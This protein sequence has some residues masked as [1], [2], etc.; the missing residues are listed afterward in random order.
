MRSHPDVERAEIAGDIRRRME[1]AGRI[2]I[3]AGCR[4]D[5]VAVA[6]SFTRI[7]AVQSATGDGASVDVQ[8]VDGA[9][10]RLH[11]VA[12][13]QFGLALWWATGNDA[14]VA[15]VAR[16][17]ATSGVSLEGGGLRDKRGGA[18]AVRDESAV[19]ASAGLSFVE[20]ELREGLGEV[21]RR[22]ARTR[23]R[24]SSARPTSAACFTATRSTP[25]AR[26]RSRRWRARRRRAGGR[27]SESPIIRE[28]AFY[29]GGLSRDAVRAQLDEIDELNATLDGFRVLKGIEADILAD[30][31]LDYGDE[32]LDAIRL[33]HR[34]DSLA[35]LDG[36]RGDDRAR[37]CA[38]ST[39][40]A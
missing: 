26:R 14:H 34:L 5:P 11:C 12:A 2:D 15:E 27:T 33:R 28:A 39:I 19:Y 29:A 40:R 13:E 3:V 9:H 30:G 20:P 7:G 10:L 21:D 24:R 17:L 8:F 35:L 18:I 25:T 31:R 32:L 6:Q 4:N 22:R 1:I 36:W 16:Q 38:R 23:C 37:A